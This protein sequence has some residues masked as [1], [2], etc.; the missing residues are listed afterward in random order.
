M[1]DTN[2]TAV[3]SYQNYYVPKPKPVASG[4]DKVFAILFLIGC[5]FTADHG[6]LGGFNLGY[7][8]CA[9]LLA[10][11]YVLYAK[12]K[13][14]TLYGT[15]CFALAVLSTTVF[16]L[17]TEPLMRFVLFFG[18]FLL[19]AI[20]ICEMY[21]IRVFAAGSWRAVADWCY[22]L[23]ICPFSGIGKTLPALFRKNGPA[24]KQQGKG[25]SVLLGIL[26]AVPVLMIV[27]PLL[28]RADEAFAKLLSFLSLD[29]IPRIIFSVVFGC[30]LFILL[31]SHAFSTTRRFNDRP[32]K[33][34]AQKA[35]LPEAPLLS[36]TG[37]ISF[38]YVLYL[39]SQI[40]YFFSAFT[41]K[42][43][44]DILPA[45]YARRGFFEMAIICVINLIILFFV[46][47]LSRREGGRIKKPIAGVCAFIDVFSLLLI[48]T[49]L[50]KMILYISRF[51]MTAKRVTTSVFMIALAFVFLALLIRLFCRKFPYMKFI[52]ITTAVIS[53]SLGLA[54]LETTIAQYNVSAYQSG[55][56]SRVDTAQLERMGG[57][58][59]PYIERLVTDKDPE[60]AEWAKEQLKERALFDHVSSAPDHDGDIRFFN[61]TTRRAKKILDKYLPADAKDP[62]TDE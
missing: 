35:F 1:Q 52:V 34:P 4:R 44:G 58:A 20:A 18:F 59:V 26:C 17:Y 19:L 15:L 23:F 46:I 24:E 41:G 42:T 27:V 36:F 30:V 10:I 25:G 54:D 53:V 9:S 47:L 55:A 61:V 49:A 57:A 22:V 32:A 37:A 7:T 14:I 29:S 56:L 38:F 5:I 48:A 13:K 62:L 40:T 39:V 50:S 21:D 8:V 51:G 45:N 2:Y 6:F 43:P 28:I 11:L 3:P 60:I 16:S 12:G 31:F 33:I